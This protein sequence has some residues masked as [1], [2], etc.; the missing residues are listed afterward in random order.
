MTCGVWPRGHRSRDASKIPDLAS[1]ST[2]LAAC[3]PRQ[4]LCEI[5]INNALRCG[6]IEIGG[7]PVIEIEHEGCAAVQAQIT[8]QGRFQIV[9]ERPHVLVHE[10]LVPGQH[11][12]II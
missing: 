1:R 10:G 7:F 11:Q 12:E 9:P 6:E 3:Q 8:G 4:R 2:G 5:R